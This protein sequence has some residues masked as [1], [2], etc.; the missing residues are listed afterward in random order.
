MVAFSIYE[1]NFSFKR[2]SIADWLLLVSS[3]LGP[4]IT[5]NA[6]ISKCHSISLLKLPRN[7]FAA[8][9]ISWKVS[10]FQLRYGAKQSFYS[11]EPFV[12]KNSFQINTLEERIPSWESHGF[13]DSSACYDQKISS[14]VT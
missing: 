1:K 9:S 13:H 5:E 11:H 3:S 10:I 7:R 2:Q 14:L 4:T 6:C 12:R 8:L